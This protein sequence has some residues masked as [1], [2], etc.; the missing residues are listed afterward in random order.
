MT[1]DDRYFARRN[2][3]TAERERLDLLASNFDPTTQRRLLM[4][5]LALEGARIL[6]VA[7]GSGSM[8]V[9][10][11][12]RVGPRGRVLAT[13]LD[14]SHLESRQHPRL[15]VRHHDIT[16]E[17]PERDAFDVAHCR[18]L[19][20][21][22][23]GTAATAIKHMV[24]ALRPGGWLLVEE[25][26]FTSSQVLSVDHPGTTAIPRLEHRSSE[27]LLAAGVMD[28]AFGRRLQPLLAAA[29]LDDV[30]HQGHVTLHRGGGPWAQQA[31]QA[32]SLMES[33]LRGKAVDEETWTAAMAAWRDPAFEFVTPINYGA[34]GRKSG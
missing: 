12:D 8:A 19:L 4:L 34:W 7:G 6:E 11:A 23:I 31:V 9:W 15:E 18:L 5:P 14:T 2:E 26:D 33:Q 29:G 24:A 30:N 16:A 27:A 3:Q 22:L 32:Y 21:H 17:P 28:C 20:M 25:P 13:D 10:M 1:D